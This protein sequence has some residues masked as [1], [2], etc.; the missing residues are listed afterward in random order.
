MP[1]SQIWPCLIDFQN[2]LGT[3]DLMLY[4]LVAFQL[5]HCAHIPLRIRISS[6]RFLGEKTAY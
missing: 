2:V 5:A 1:E 3:P 4:T 6:A